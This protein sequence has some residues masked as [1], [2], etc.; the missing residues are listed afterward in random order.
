MTGVCGR[1]L[2]VAIM[3]TAPTWALAAPVSP[4]RVCPEFPT[5]RKVKLQQVADGMEVNGVPMTIVRM[6]SDEPIKTMQTFFRNA[7]ASGDKRLAPVEYALGPWQVV[8]AQRGDCFYTAQLK[9]FGRDGTEGLL[10]ISA[11]PGKA[12]VQEAVPML[13][14][15]STLN[16]LAHN[17]GGRT[18]RTVLV[19]NGFSTAAN[20]DFYRRNLESEGWK[21]TNHY[22]LQQPENKGDVLV[23]RQ[24]V[25]E[26]SIT[27]TRDPQ[28]ARQSNVLLNYVDQP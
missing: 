3:A 25:R 14:G 22:R 20:A 27:A 4:A 10:G 5:P 7:W 2:T 1:W 6:E 8:A 28:D 24:G 21:V 26:L 13:P 12:R 11:P 23:L 9:P 17:D 19:K 15:S 16:D 18:A